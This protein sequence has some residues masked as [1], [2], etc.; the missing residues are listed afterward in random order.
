MAQR[1]SWPAILGVYLFAVA[2]GA[3]VPKLIPLSGDFARMFGLGPAGFGWLVSVIAIPAALLAIPSGV[4]V[5]RFG[6]RAV[7]IGGALV[8][9]CAN[10]LYIAATSVPML[11]VA[12]LIEGAAIVHIYTAG[13]AM[14]M[15]MTEC[16][17]RTA[18]MSVWT[19]YMPVGTAIA[20]AVAGAFAD[21]PGWHAVFFGHGSLFL[22]AAAIGFTLPKPDR[23][24]AAPR[25]TL[26]AQL[27]ELRLAYSRPT[28]LMLAFA[29]F[30]MI[31]IGLGA[32]VAFPQYFARVLGLS[33]GQ[34]ASMVAAT[35]LIMVPGSLL[36]GFVLSRGV[37][38]TT[39][40]AAIAAIGFV[41]GTMC[42]VPVLA[43]PSRY[44]VLAIWFLTSGASVATLMAVLPLVAEPERRGAA[45][46][47]L[48]QAAALATFVNP[49]IWLAFAGTNGWTPFAGLLAIGWSCATIAVWLATSMSRAAAV[50]IA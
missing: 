11:Q 50:R 48:N 47:L 36:A 17:R 10:L 43:L 44:L 37:K 18:A 9:A 13:P 25:R 31:S 14:L 46:A 41:A 8:A 1:G 34:A 5:D 19:T 45:A 12:R 2:A 33:M 21:G 27:I 24:A 22:V 6:P 40:F 23:S 49:P 42:F 35:T 15:G 30:L 26:A 3:T 7:L 4:V 38:P 32:N 29:F 39:V 16:K 20:L 28:L